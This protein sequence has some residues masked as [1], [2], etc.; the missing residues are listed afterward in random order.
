M[1]DGEWQFSILYFLFST[2]G[3]PQ[4][5]APENLVYACHLKNSNKAI[6]RT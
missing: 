3:G 1:E 2:E 4:K 6:N 5:A